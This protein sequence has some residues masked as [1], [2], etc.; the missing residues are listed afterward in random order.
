[1]KAASDGDNEDAEALT[2]EMGLASRHNVHQIFT[3][4]IVSVVQLLF[5]MSRRLNIHTFI[6][7]SLLN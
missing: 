3:H 5:F 4:N 7:N 1:M 2:K 6:E